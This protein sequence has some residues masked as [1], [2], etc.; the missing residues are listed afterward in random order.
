M[1]SEKQNDATDPA[2]AGAPDTSPDGR[3]GPRK[4][5]RKKVKETVVDHTY[6]DYSQV[7]VAP[8]DDDDDAGAKK[9]GKS[10]HVNFPVRLHE[11]V[12]NPN[13]QHIV[14]WMVR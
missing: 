11:I 7:K 13:Y 3:V 9:N 2:A 8:S 6:R 10:K 4:H 12:S 5:P 14:C 1:Q